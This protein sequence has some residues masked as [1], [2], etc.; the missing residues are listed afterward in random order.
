MVIRP[1]IL[2]ILAVLPLLAPEIWSGFRLGVSD[3]VLSVIA[4]TE[5]PLSVRS[6]GGLWAMALVLIW[7]SLAYWRRDAKLWEAAL[8]II[9][10]AAALT[11]LGNA[12]VDAVAMVLPLGRQLASL[13]LKPVVVTALGAICVAATL[14]TATLTRPP[15]LPQAA[16]QVAIGA[17]TGGKV[18]ADWRWAPEVQSQL[19]SRRQVYAAG[20][21][22]SESADF[23]VDYLRIAQGHERWAELLRGMGVDLVV[24]D[25][26]DQQ[27]QAAELI[28]A[29]SDWRVTFDSG[30]TLVAERRSP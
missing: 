26:A 16:R 22:A 4:P 8:V 11:R 5:Q 23:W 30:G 9:G 19:G 21:L 1:Y 17:S 28:R 27:H 15:E 10:G 24:M 6:P 12:W 14:A 3:T 20:G 7:F 13:D 2:A 29:S 18:I 25:S